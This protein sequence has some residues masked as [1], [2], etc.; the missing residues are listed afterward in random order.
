MWILF[1][2]TLWGGQETL[3]AKEK[4]YGEAVTCAGQSNFFTRAMEALAK[5][6]ENTEEATKKI[7]NLLPDLYELNT[8]STSEAIKQGLNQGISP[9]KTEKSIE[10]V[11][12]TTRASMR[13]IDDSNMK[14]WWSALITKMQASMESCAHYTAPKSW[15]SWFE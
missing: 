10:E 2:I 12:E 5:G 6:E 4:T 1:L 13:A 7:N 8:K 9:Q 15:F 3:A 11:R 14:A